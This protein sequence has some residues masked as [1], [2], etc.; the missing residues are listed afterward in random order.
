MKG[1]KHD[2]NALVACN[3]LYRKSA[4]AKIGGEVYIFNKVFWLWPYFRHDHL[5]DHLAGNAVR[6][7]VDDTSRDV[8]KEG[9]GCL[10]SM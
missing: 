1:R 10:M 5:A 6:S 4:Q 2:V 7:G 3:T 8:E 9:T